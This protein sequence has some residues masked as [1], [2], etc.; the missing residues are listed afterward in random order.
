MVTSVKPGL[1]KP[2]TGSTWNFVELKIIL[3]WLG[4]FSKKK[5]KKT[6]YFVLGYSRL[7]VLIVSGK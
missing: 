2:V 4:L 1:L 7:T 6:F 5:Q 3:S